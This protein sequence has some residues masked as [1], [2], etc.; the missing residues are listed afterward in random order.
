[1]STGSNSGPRGVGEAVDGV[2]DDD[3]EDADGVGA[4]RDVKG[5]GD[6]PLGRKALRRAR[7]KR[8]SRVRHDSRARARGNPGFRA[9]APA[10]GTG[11][12]TGER[13]IRA[14]VNPKPQTLNTKP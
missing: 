14:R 11:H 10:H 7:G 1:M 8:R 6:L 3:G 12:P 5:E 2:G 4:R 13:S 9:V